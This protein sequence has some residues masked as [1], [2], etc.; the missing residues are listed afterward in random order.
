M[1]DP[2]DIKVNLSV[3]KK[4]ENLSNKQE[5][6]ELKTVMLYENLMSNGNFTKNKK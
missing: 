5:I 6:K 4:S 2:K 1:A 3:V